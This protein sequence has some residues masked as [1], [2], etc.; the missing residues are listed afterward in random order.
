MLKNIYA[1]FPSRSFSNDCVWEKTYFGPSHDTAVCVATVFALSVQVADW[2]HRLLLAIIAVVTLN[3]AEFAVHFSS[4][5]PV[6]SF[7]N[8]NIWICNQSI[9][10]WVFLRVCLYVLLTTSREKEKF[11]LSFIYQHSIY[12]ML[13]FEKTKFKWLNCWEWKTWQGLTTNQ[14]HVTTKKWIYLVTFC[15]KAYVFM[16]WYIS[17]VSLL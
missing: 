1:L 8:N 9:I 16:L 5:L 12:L 11:L 13:W 15:E 6:M 7:A 3:L 2:Y 4:S 10:S 17:S 14:L